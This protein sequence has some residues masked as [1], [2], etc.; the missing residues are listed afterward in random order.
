MAA[1]TS[2]D[3]DVNATIVSK[4][5]AT[6]L[7]SGA[8]GGSLR[9]QLSERS[10][11]APLQTNMSAG[12]KTGMWHVNQIAP[13]TNLQVSHGSGQSSSGMKR[14]LSF[15]GTAERSQTRLASPTADQAHVYFKKEPT[16]F[17]GSA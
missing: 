14:S 7:A 10:L 15:R 2:R 13:A 8:A 5:S 3:D 6:R 9:R 4:S 12:Q 11:D 17:S 1:A 16:A